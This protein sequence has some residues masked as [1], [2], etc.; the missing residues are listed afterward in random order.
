MEETSN[1][2]N[3]SVPGSMNPLTFCI[4]NIGVDPT[5]LIEIY[6]EMSQI[7]NRNYTKP[8]QAT[9]Y[10]YHEYYEKLNRIFPKIRRG[11]IIT[12]PSFD[13]VCGDGDEMKLK[14]KEF[15]K[16]YVE[17]KN[18]KGSFGSL[19]TAIISGQNTSKIPCTIKVLDLQST[20]SIYSALTEI[21][22]NILLYINETTRNFVPVIYTA[23]IDNF[24]PSDLLESNRIKPHKI[25]IVMED[26][27]EN[28]YDYL[29]K[30]KTR[31][32][33]QAACILQIAN[34]LSK[35][36][37]VGFRHRDF[38]AGNVLY[39]EKT[40]DD[41]LEYKV[42]RNTH[43]LTLYDVQFVMIDFGLSCMTHEGIDIMGSAGVNGKNIFEGE[44]KKTNNNVDLGKFIVDIS[45]KNVL[46]E[47]I[48]GILFGL[49]VGNSVRLGYYGKNIHDM[50]IN[51]QIK[52][53]RKLN[54][55]NNP[56]LYPNNVI[57]E[58]H[59]YLSQDNNAPNS[60]RYN[61]NGN[62]NSNDIVRRSLNHSKGNYTQ[63]FKKIT[64]GSPSRLIGCS[65]D[66]TYPNRT[67]TVDFAK[68]TITYK[69]GVVTSAINFT[70][71]S[72]INFKNITQIKCNTDTEN[73]RITIVENES[74]AENCIKFYV[75]G[76][77][78]E[79]RM[80][81]LKKFYTNVIHNI[82]RD[83][84]NIKKKGK[85]DNTLYDERLDSNYSEYT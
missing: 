18:V 23:F 9:V 48:V 19:H 47:D 77:T 41:I 44:C 46:H 60:P 76:N 74:D 68:K 31:P 28:V 55:T 30:N 1:P 66:Y 6:N 5:R 42:G 36:E 70:S 2:S 12:S 33:L 26:L 79:E 24:F 37:S 67:V 72:T 22:I 85:C 53:F 83:N 81:N 51:E 15:T 54:S 38:H 50:S 63:E 13:L 4:E 3:V 11:K 8:T 34:I 10:K 75:D 65:E 40:R 84:T 25:G 14:I 32:K 64:E 78:P 71:N 16:M 29:E 35:M 56:N 80:T 49:L 17:K 21:L 20:N 69:S 52:R 82:L 45:T 73:Q 27:R 7:Q 61:G 62:G 57:Q 43:E 39:R 59:E 58:M